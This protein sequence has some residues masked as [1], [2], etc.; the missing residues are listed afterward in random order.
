MVIGAHIGGEDIEKSLLLFA[1]KKTAS[2][3]PDNRFIFFTNSPLTHL[4]PNCIQVNVNPR[5]ANKILLYYW[6]NYKL[7]KLLLKYSIKSF[8]SNVGML[9]SSNEAKQF[10]FIEHK[11]LLEER[12]KFYTKRLNDALV[13]AQTVF[14]IDDVVGDKI[15]K[16]SLA[17]A[18]KIQLLNFNLFRNITPFTFNDIEAAR[19]KYTEGFDYYLFRI[20]DTSKAQIITLLKSFSQLKKWQKTSLKMILLFE[21]DI[22]EQLLLDF[23]NYKYRNEIILL[24]ETK[25]NV[26]LLTAAAFCYIYFN[27]YKSRAY[28]YNAFKYNVPVIAADT[29]TNNLLFKST[30]SYS[31]AS[32][33]VLA[34]QLQ[35]I[36]KDEVYRKQLLQKANIHLTL[37]DSDA[38]SQNVA[39]I[40]SNS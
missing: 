36:Y 9:T 11:D 4:P 30:V 18:V 35:L 40:I 23:K 39:D 14:V 12:N 1:L 10:L 7:P 22:D 13:I 34:R 19:E 6:Y 25:E 26:H 24:K 38:A 17:D 15:N 2:I 21:K 27:D 8:I 33:D 28:V 20:D 5:P 16:L 37:F 32:V 29:I 3:Q 31:A